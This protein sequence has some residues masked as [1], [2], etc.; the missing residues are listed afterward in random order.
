MGLRLRELGRRNEIPEYVSAIVMA[1]LQKDPGKR[2]QSMRVIREWIQEAEEGVREKTIR[3]HQS[4]EITTRQSK[5]VAPPT[6]KKDDSVGS[7][8]V[9]RKVAGMG[10]AGPKPA[11]KVV[12]RQDDDDDEASPWYKNKEKKKLAVVAAI[13]LLV[14]IPFG[15]PSVVKM[16]DAGWGNKVDGIVKPWKWFGSDEYLGNRSK[17]IRIDSITIAQGLWGISHVVGDAKNTSSETLQQV[18]LRFHLFDLQDKKLGEAVEYKDEMGPGSTWSF[19]AACMFTN[20]A[21]ADLV[22]VIVR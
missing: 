3:K 7:G 13:F 8:S 6:A 17:D 11:F 4:D 9:Q 15:F 16:I 1:C 21:R 14:F 5:T 20:V 2:P 12:Y 18:E 22:E 10:G 19:R